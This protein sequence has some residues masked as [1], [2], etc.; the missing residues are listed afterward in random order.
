MQLMST[1]CTYHLGAVLYG[2]E[3]NLLQCHTRQI[4]QC[5]KGTRGIYLQK[6]GK[7]LIL[8]CEEGKVKYPPSF[9][10]K[11]AKLPRAK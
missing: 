1:N 3:D 8:V 5:L 6:D 10:K 4:R 11:L 2:K 7:Y 9:L